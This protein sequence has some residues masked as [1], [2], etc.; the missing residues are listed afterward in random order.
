M[1]D[2]VVIQLYTIPE[3]A[4]RLAMSERWVQQQIAAGRLRALSLGRSR[5]V[6][7]GELRAFVAAREREARRGA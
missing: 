4:A 7:E 6:T 2:P 1:R 3:V 5:R